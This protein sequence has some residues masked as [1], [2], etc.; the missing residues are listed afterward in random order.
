MG[1]RIGLLVASLALLAMFAAAD[2]VTT[3][4]WFNTPS[5][6]SFSVTLPGR[7]AIASGSTSD[8]EYNS[9]TPTA[10][11]INC[12]VRATPW[13]SQTESVPCFNYSNTGNREINVT[14]QFGS[15]LPAGV[16]VKAGWNNSAWVASCSCTKL[17]A[18]GSNDC[19]N[20]TDTSAVTVATI[21]YAGYQEVW[22]WADFSS[23]SGGSSNSRTLTHTSLSST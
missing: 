1:L 20:V 18:C 9:S 3:T 8:V 7:G 17:P 4:V 22:M 19:V 6:V 12:S 10:E 23:Y 5:D 2:T 11:K 21:A 15:A 16:A 13:S 14:M